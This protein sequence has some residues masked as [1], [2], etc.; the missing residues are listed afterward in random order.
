MLETPRESPHFK[1]RDRRHG[2][3]GEGLVEL[4]WEEIRRYAS[5]DKEDAFQVGKNSWLLL[6]KDSVTTGF[7]IDFI[8]KLIK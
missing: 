3:A 4:R 6:F 5:E 7:F 1:I 8:V 2:S